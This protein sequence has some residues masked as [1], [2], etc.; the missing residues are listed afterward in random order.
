V[1]IYAGADPAETFGPYDSPEWIDAKSVSGIDRQSAAELERLL[2]VEKPLNLTLV[3]AL[4]YRQVNVRSLAARCLSFLGDFA[5]LVEELNDPRQYS[6]WASGFAA[7]RQAIQGGPEAALTVK[8]TLERLRPDQAADLY[9]LL[10]SYS[11]DQ[12]AKGSDLEL[13]EFLRSDHMD[14]RVLAFQNLATITGAYE[15]YMPQKRPE[16]LKAAIQNW[17]ARQAKGTITYRLPPAPI[18]AY[19]P[20]GKPPA[21]A[22]DLPAPRGAVAPLAPL[23][24]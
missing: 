2:D 3:E 11:P 10:W 6:F 21:A 5:P 16:D 20:L 19:K 14:V 24:P 22:I 12:L 17:K 9:R 23:E 18:E 1:R 4:E 15:F 7:L 8:A 13:V